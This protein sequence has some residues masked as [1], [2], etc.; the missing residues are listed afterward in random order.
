MGHG[1]SR[2]RYPLISSERSDCTKQKT[3]LKAVSSSTRVKRLVKFCFFGG[4]TVSLWSLKMASTAR[5]H[6]ILLLDS[7]G[8]RLAVQ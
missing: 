3:T 4:I 5:V 8:G 6:G 2:L 1:Y 7:D